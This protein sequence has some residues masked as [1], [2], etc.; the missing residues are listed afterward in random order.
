MRSALLAY[1]GIMCAI[2]LVV[3]ISIITMKS[4]YYELIRQSLDDSL[5]YTIGLV[6]IDRH[7]EAGATGEGGYRDISWASGDSWTNT[8]SSETDKLVNDED[9]K[10]KFVEYLASN[11]DSKIDK[12]SID[13]YGADS[14]YGVISVKV[15]A[16]FKY[17]F[18]KQDY[19]EVVKTILLNKEIFI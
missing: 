5:E 13:L 6:Q 9:F 4:S 15:R 18:G 19:V 16:D 11:I 1:T 12:I 14:E 10:R 17:P 7:L 2:A 8:Q 3:I